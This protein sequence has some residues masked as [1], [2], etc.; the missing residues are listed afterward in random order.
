MFHPHI[1]REIPCIPWAFIF[2][3]G[4]TDLASRLVRQSFQ[5]A[6]TDD[7]AACHS[8][9]GSPVAGSRSGMGSIMMRLQARL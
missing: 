5:P 7:G 1:L 8:G 6:S 3:Q 4:S 2:R 9:I